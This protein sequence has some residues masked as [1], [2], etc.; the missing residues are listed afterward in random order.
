MA[1]EVGLGN[2]PKRR[3]EPDP[4]ALRC[5]E[6]PDGVVAVTLVKDEDVGFCA[7]IEIVE[8]GAAADRIRSALA[9]QRVIIRPAQNDVVAGPALD[10][11]VPSIAADSIIAVEAP[12]PV[13]TISAIQGVA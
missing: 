6:V 10:I 3:I 9:E 7:P 4:I 12:Q 11:V 1:L 2:D 13:V 5:V 8:A